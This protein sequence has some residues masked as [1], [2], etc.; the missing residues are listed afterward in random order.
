MQIEV[1]HVWI[2]KSIVEFGVALMNLVK[3]IW[4]L[5]SASIVN[6]SYLT[7]YIARPHIS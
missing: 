7:I 5:S 4:L 1:A 3:P 6:D 2:V